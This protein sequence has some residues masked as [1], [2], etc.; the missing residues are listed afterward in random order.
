MGA[1]G[2]MPPKPHK[3]MRLGEPKGRRAKSPAQIVE[4]VIPDGVT[5]EITAL[6][7]EALRVAGS[8]L[9]WGD[10][11]PSPHKTGIRSVLCRDRSQLLDL[12]GRSE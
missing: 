9:V 3:D 4:I 10:A 12:L 1:L 7:V 6:S 5:I 8:S 2:R 11:L